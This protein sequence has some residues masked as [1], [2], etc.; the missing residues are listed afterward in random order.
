MTPTAA[1]A[2]S[3]RASAVPARPSPSFFA[4]GIFFL[5]AAGVSAAGALFLGQGSLWHRHAALEA[6]QI[7]WVAFLK[8]GA[9]RAPVEEVLR[10]LP[11]LRTLRFVSKEEAL[12]SAKADPVF[13]EGLSLTGGNPFP[14]SFVVQWAPLFLRGDLLE[15]H[16]RRVSSLEGV[17]HVDWDRPRA[18]RFSLVQKALSQTDL[19]VETLT[20]LAA[21]LLLLLAGRILFFAPRPPSIAAL[22][23]G[24]LSAA[25][26]AAAGGLAAWYSGLPADLPSFLAGAVAASVLVLGLEA[27]KT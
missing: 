1:S 4:L 17:D 20:A 27:F 2:P 5:T 13:T 16:A 11:G 6:D 19:A 21:A 7:Q 3:A 24:A 12:A 22:L 15:S 26:G 14:D 10:A 25:T 9:D 8:D 23:A 18:D